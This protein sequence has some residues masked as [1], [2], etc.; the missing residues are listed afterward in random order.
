MRRSHQ[1]LCVY[2]IRLITGKASCG[3]TLANG[4]CWDL[5]YPSV[6]RYYTDITSC[7]VDTAR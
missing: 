4:Q 3:R 7:V 5:V 6:L 2:P 1:G